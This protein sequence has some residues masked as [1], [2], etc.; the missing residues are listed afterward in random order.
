MGRMMEKPRDIRISKEVIYVKNHK[1]PLLILRPD[2]QT[3]KRQVCCG[4][5]V[6]DIFSE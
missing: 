6:V 1:I 2:H 4:F 3:E 5:T